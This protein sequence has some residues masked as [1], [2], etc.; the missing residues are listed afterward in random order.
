MN[1]FKIGEKYL[2]YF[3]YIYVYIIWDVVVLGVMFIA[4]IPELNVVLNITFDDNSED[5]VG[6]RSVCE[7]YEFELN[8]EQQ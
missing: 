5:T 8:Q 6:G 3:Y 7:W 1:I 4:D 2:P